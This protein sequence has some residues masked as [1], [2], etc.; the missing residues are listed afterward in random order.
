MTQF[1]WQVDSRIFEIDVKKR[2]IRFFQLDFILSEDV[3]SHG[4]FLTVSL[5]EAV[6]VW[7]LCE[8]KAI[9]LIRFSVVRSDHSF[10]RYIE[11]RGVVYLCDLFL[12]FVAV[13]H[14]VNLV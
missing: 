6:G 4:D 14:L 10:T 7:I 12:S 11:I 2:L 9:N 3:L 13:N 5:N 1:S 8:V